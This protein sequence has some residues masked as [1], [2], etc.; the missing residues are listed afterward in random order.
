MKKIEKGTIIRTIV[1]ALAL[2][3]QLLIASGKT[4]IEVGEP[5]VSALIN[6]LF[7]II[8]A[9]LAWWKNNSF[10]QK[11]IEADEYRKTLK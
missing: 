6:T 11:A 5:E 2:I 7:T 9:V 3:N 10:T 1:L 8:T 4:V